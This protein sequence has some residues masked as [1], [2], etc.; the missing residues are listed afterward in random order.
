MFELLILDILIQIVR[1]N[2]YTKL[3]FKYIVFIYLNKCGFI[4]LNVKLR[5]FRWT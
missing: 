1:F 5:T 3:V 2:L 4:K